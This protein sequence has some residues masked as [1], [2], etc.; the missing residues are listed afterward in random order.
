[1]WRRRRQSDHE[2]DATRRARAAAQEAAEA[3][4][5]V[6]EQWPDVQRISRALNTALSRNHF[7]ESIE[8]ALRRRRA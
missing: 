7:G 2:S 5:Q 3:R 8:L 6:D 4:R 1:M